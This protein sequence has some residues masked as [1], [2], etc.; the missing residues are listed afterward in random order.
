MV[1]LVRVA[2]RMI[3]DFDDETVRKERNVV[4]ERTRSAL[5]RKSKIDDMTIVVHK[6]GTIPTD[7]LSVQK[8]FVL[9]FSCVS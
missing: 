8:R 4:D 6:H 7:D 5:S 2:V 3:C 9:R 1:S